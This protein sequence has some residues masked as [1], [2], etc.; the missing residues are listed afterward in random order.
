[1]HLP[2]WLLRL[3]GALCIVCACGLARAGSVLFVTSSPVA[4]G[5]FAV[6][7]QAGA[8]LGLRIEVRYVEKLPPGTPPP[9][10][11][12]G[13]DLVLFDTPRQHIEDFVRSKLDAALPALATRPHAWLSTAAVRAGGGLDAALAQRLH[14]YHVNGGQANR[15]HLL[16]TLAAHLKGRPWQALPAPQVFPAAGVYHP[17]APGL[18]LPSAAAYLDWLGVDPA[19]RPPTVAIAFHQQ[20]IA[21]EQTGFIDDLVARIEAAGAIALPFYGGVMEPDAVRRMLLQG[22]RPVADVLVNTQ[23]TLNP[24]GRRREFEALGLPVVQAMAYRRGDATQWAADPQGVQ[25]MDV[26]FYLAQAEYAGITDIQIAMATRAADEQVEPIAPQAAAVVAK[27]LNLVRLQ[28]KPAAD[29]HVAILFWNYPGGEKNLSASFMNLP[30]SLSGTLAALRAAG[31]RTEALPESALTPQLQRLLAPGYR[32][33]DDQDVLRAL[34]RDGLAD[35]LPVAQYSAWLQ[36]LPATVQA[37]LQQRWGAPERSAMVLREGAAA[38]FVVPR[39]RL[40]NVSLLPQPARGER[41]DDKER[42]LYHSTSAVPPH[43]YLATY[44]WAR[45]RFGADALVHFGTHGTQEWLPGKERGLSVFDHPMLAVGDVPVLYPY[46]VDN[47]G[48]ATQAKRRGRAVILSHQTPPFAPAGLHAALTNIHDLLHQWQAQDEGGVKQQLRLQFLAAVRAER[49]DRDLGWSAARSEAEFPAFVQLVHDHLHE[50]A[51]T[52]QPMGLHTFGAGSE[53]RWRIATVLTMLG[54]DFWEAMAGPGEEPDEQLVADW[55]ALPQSTPYRRLQALL[56]DGTLPDGLDA[57]TRARAQQARGWYAALGADNELRALLAGLEGRHIPTSGGGD[58][59]RNPDSLPT[60]RNL[61]GFDPSRVPTQAAWQAGKLALERLLDTHR[62]QTGGTPAK[63]A[64]TLWSVETMR[65]FGLLEA[66]ALWALGVEPVWDAGGRVTGVRLVPRAQLGRPRV[67]VVL[68][69]TG[70][71]RDHFPNVMRQLARAAQLAADAQED[72]NTVAANSRRIAQQLQARGL[73]AGAAQQAAATRIFS[74]ASGS[75]GSG[76]DQAALATDTWKTQAEGDRKLAALYL[77]RMQYAYGPDEAQWGSGPPAAAGGVNLYAEH[78]R[79]TQGA[80]LARSSHLYGMLTTDDPFQYL[81]GIGLAV[82]QLD[83]QAPALYISNLR[84][85][86]SNG[87][88][89]VEGAAQF[90]AKE[91]ATRNFHPGH[92]SG[93]MAEGYSGTLQVLDGINNFAGWQSVARE[94]V[95][96]DQWQEFMDVYVRDKHRLGLQR[97]FEAHNPHALAQ[98]IERMLE[99]ARQGQWQADAASVAELQARY[100][101]LARRFA[102]RS[103]NAA[104]EAFVGSLGFGLQAAVPAAAA[105]AAP[106][107]PAPEPAPVP[108]PPAVQGLRLDRVPPA[109]D[110]VSV[111]GALAALCLLALAL[112]GGVWRG[113]RA[114]RVTPTSRSTPIALRT[115]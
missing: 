32:P 50:L 104:F 81:G 66:Q 27:A 113:S 64:F 55:Q 11:W 46:I 111:T 101:A 94:I 26:P 22:G 53:E 37:G 105:V 41:G 100:R 82:R 51:R 52:A 83:G 1:M 78:L 109:A 24:D 63:L 86:G 110:P 15:T 106:P 19:R 92:I 57:A 6:L 90:L 7:A 8:A 13:A 115:A 95:R 68:S 72:D 61:Y 79:G 39:L 69:A 43:H 88:G 44:L 12:Q 5:K 112:A 30:R 87:A 58:P 96:H 42:A 29:K 48:E 73:D 28:R 21:A 3:G 97:W 45:T 34:L 20:S 33:P 35:R 65:H 25:L 70:L 102:V 107:P 56:Q 2:T 67:D 62:R 98:S 38:V 60:G 40:G 36:T 76:L 18:V 49:I 14:A 23:I 114:D 59:I 99:A 93:L 103:D 89:R 54:R 47:I 108:A 4:P 91:L 9:A 75:Y 80:V 16:Q 74:S 85:G 77:S 31:Y 84:D 10:L 17:R 71:Y